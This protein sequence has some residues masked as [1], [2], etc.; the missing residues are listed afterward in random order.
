VN[1]DISWMEHRI[2]CILAALEMEKINEEHWKDHLY[3][4]VA[5]VEEGE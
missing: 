4:R 3:A 2:W 1:V 5:S